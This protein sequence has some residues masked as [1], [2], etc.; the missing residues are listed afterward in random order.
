[1][2]R[3]PTNVAFY[4]CYW[5]LTTYKFRGTE[6]ACALRENTRCAFLTA[7]ERDSESGLDYFINRYYSSAHGRFSSVDPENAGANEDDPQSWNGYSYARSNPVLYT[8]PDGLAYIVCDPNGKNCSTVSDQQFYD[9]RRADT[10]AG[11]EYTG[12]RDF[13]EGGQIK[14]DGQVQ[15]TYQQISIDDPTREFIFQMRRQTAPIPKATLAFFGL[16]AA[17]GTGG[18]VAYYY[19]GTSALTTGANL[20]YRGYRTLKVLQNVCFVAGTPV[21]TKDGIKPIEEIKVGDEVLSY[22]ETT[23]RVEYKA[24]VQAF[25]KFSEDILSVSVEGESLPLGVTPNHPFYVRVHRARDNTGNDDDEGE[26][27]EASKLKAGNKIK[28][29][30]GSWAKVLKIERRNGGETV[31]NFEV[32]DNHNYFVGQTGLLAHNTCTTILQKALKTAKQVGDRLEATLKDGSKVVFRKDFGAKAHPIGSKYLNPVNHY[33]IEIHVPYRG[34]YKIALDA[35]VIVD[36]AGK[37]IDII[38]K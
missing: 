37:V 22:N 2:R 15:Y 7:K 25:K 4:S 3:S 16:S 1:V 10:K 20:A 18:G 36:S 23:K 19:L 6:I 12:N 24:V 8:D 21:W 13:F 32:A 26:W 11:L 38:T 35:H 31:Y 30:S 9:A 28:L 14:V 17:L 5:S 33:N 34:G 29:A 27:L